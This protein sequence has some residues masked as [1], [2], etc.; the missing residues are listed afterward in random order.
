MKIKSKIFL[1]MDGV[2]A[3]FFG[4]TAKLCSKKHYKELTHDDI[5]N[6]MESLP[7]IDDYFAKL[8]VFKSNIV[9]LKR[10]LDVAG[11]YYI[12]SSPLQDETEPEDSKRNL[13]F[14][15]QS[16]IGKMLW[17]HNNLTP[18]P[19]RI[20]FSQDKWKDAPAVEK[21]GTINVLIDDKKS[22]IE[23]W[24]KA[25]GIGIKF[26]ADEHFDDP[27]L[28]F[29]QK[30]LEKAIKKINKESKYDQVFDDVMQKKG[31]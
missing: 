17:I 7:N 25:G 26:Q 14:N 27:E 22:N 15:R 8:P 24:E 11:C 18:Q 23:A 31:N 9:L 5:F 29:I 3:D 16:M 13:F 1:D 4:E 30:E 10:V 2:I 20:C 12:C 19:E 21:D 28:Y 6:L